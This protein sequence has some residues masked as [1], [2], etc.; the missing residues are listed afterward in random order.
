MPAGRPTK[1]TQEILDTAYNYLE[2]YSEYGVVPSTARLARILNIARS[3]VYEW[4]NEYPE[5]KDILESI[6]AEQ[7]AMLIDNGL[8]GDFVSPITKLLLT[9]HG[10]TD[11]I[12]QD[13]SSTDGTMKP[14]SIH[15]VGV[16]TD[17]E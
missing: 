7:E 9:K 5:F 11:R 6:Q 17:D 10:Y 8:T 16:D 14:V 3:R 2:N 12:E 15:L 13:L 4:G 1:Y